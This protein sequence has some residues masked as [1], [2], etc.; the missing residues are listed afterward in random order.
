MYV[1]VYMYVCYVCMYGKQNTFGPKS[2][3]AKLNR[4]QSNGYEIVAK[5]YECTLALESI[6]T[7]VNNQN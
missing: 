1:H 4:D 2:S 7:Y 3:V 5:D 6:C